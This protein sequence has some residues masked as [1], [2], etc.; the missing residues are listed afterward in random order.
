VVIASA[1][2]EAAQTVQHLVSNIHFRAYTSSDV[3]GVELAGALKNVIAI[4]AGI[5]DAL[6]FGHNT[7]AALITRGI[8]EMTRLSLKLGA[9]KETFLGLAGIGDLVLTCTARMSRNYH[10]GY[11]LGKGRRLAEVLAETPMV[12]EGVTT[13][14]SVRDLSRREEV[15]MPISTEV[16]RILYENKSP[17]GSIGD[18][19]LR[20]LKGE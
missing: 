5:S 2:G 12:A 9:K 4:A 13:T 3:I 8:A 1:L 11:E 6:S 19:M 7:R 20:T 16:Y 18:L 14:V 15:E 10:V 17:K